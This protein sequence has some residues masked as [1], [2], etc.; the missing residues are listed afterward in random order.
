MRPSPCH[1]QAVSR[2]GAAVL[3]YGEAITYLIRRALH[4]SSI[5]VVKTGAKVLRQL[6]RG[7][8]Q[9]Y[10]AELRSHPPTLWNDPVFQGSHFHFW[11]Q[12]YQKVPPPASKFG[13]PPSA[14]SLPLDPTWHKPS[15][16]ELAFAS[17][18]YAHFYFHAL[19]A[20]GRFVAANRPAAAEAAGGPKPTGG[21]AKAAPEVPPATCAPSAP[22]A[23]SPPSGATPSPTDVTALPPRPRA[24]LLGALVLIKNL[25]R[26]AGALVPPLGT[27]APGDVSRCPGP[28]DP[29]LSRTSKPA[30]RPNPALHHPKRLPFT[31]HT[32]ALHH[33]KPCLSHPKRLPFTSHTPALHIPNPECLSLSPNPASLSSLSV[34]I[35]SRPAPCPSVWSRNSSHHTRRHPTAPA[36]ATAA[37]TPS[38]GEPRL[39][40]VMTHL[41]ATQLEALARTEGPGQTFESGVGA[42][43]E[44]AEGLEEME[45]AGEGEGEEDDEEEEDEEDED[46]E[47]SEDERQQPQQPQPAVTTAEKTEG[48]PRATGGAAGTKAPTPLSLN[49]QHSSLVTNTQSVSHAPAFLP[50][51]PDVQPSMRVR[52]PGLRD[53]HALTRRGARALH[54]L[55]AVLLARFPD[56]V[57]AQKLLVQAVGLFFDLTLSLSTHSSHSIS[58]M[59]ALP[60][61]GLPVLR[62]GAHRRAIQ[63]QVKDFHS[64]RGFIRDPVGKAHQCRPLLIMRQFIMSQVWMRKA[65]PAV[66]AQTASHRLLLDDLLGLSTSAYVKIRR[67]SQIALTRCLSVDGSRARDGVLPG[68]A[69]PAGAARGSSGAADA[70]LQAQHAP[71][72]DR[73]DPLPALCGPPAG[74]HQPRVQQSGQQLLNSLI[75]NSHLMPLQ[76]LS[77]HLVAAEQTQAGLVNPRPPRGTAPHCRGKTRRYWDRRNEA[78]R[79]Q[80]NDLAGYVFKNI[81]P[82]SHRGL[83]EATPP[84]TP[85]GISRPGSAEPETVPSSAAP[86]ATIPGLPAAVAQAILGGTPPPTPAA[87]PTPQGGEGGEALLPYHW[88]YQPP[89]S[90]PMRPLARF[91]STLAPPIPHAFHLRST[92]SSPWGVSR[93]VTIPSLCALAPPLARPPHA[94]L[95]FQN[96]AMLLVRPRPLPTLDMMT[97]LLQ[98]CASELPYSRS[99]SFRTFGELVAVVREKAPKWTLPTHG[100]RPLT[101]G[102]MARMVEANRMPLVPPPTSSP[103]QLNT[104]W[105]AQSFVDRNVLGW[106]GFPMPHFF[107]HPGPH[108]EMAPP[109]G[110]PGVDDERAT[111]EAVQR[112]RE[113]LYG[114]EARM[115]VTAPS[116]PASALGTTMGSL[117]AS[118]TLTQAQPS[119]QAAHAAALASHLRMAP[120]RARLYEILAAQPDLLSRI[121]RFEAEVQRSSWN[122]TDSLFFKSLFQLGGLPIYELCKPHV[123]ALVARAEDLNA[124]FTVAEFISGLCRATKGWPYTDIVRLWA[125]EDTLVPGTPDLWNPE[126]P[127]PAPVHGLGF[128]AL[129]D[130]LFRRSAS[131]TLVIYAAAVN[132]GVFDL[133][134]RRL[135][136]MADLLLNPLLG[137]PT[138]VSSPVTAS[139]SP[140]ASPVGSPTALPALEPPATTP[141]APALSVAFAGHPKAAAGVGV[142]AGPGTEHRRMTLLMPLVR[143]CSW[144]GLFYGRLLAGRLLWFVVVVAGGDCG[145][146]FKPSG[147]WAVAVMR[148]VW[149]AVETIMVK[150]RKV[151]EK[152]CSMQGSNLRPLPY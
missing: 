152:M 49:S 19:R 63:S 34:W 66:R 103:H 133:D 60:G 145:G 48:A 120:Y 106:N 105:A 67:A 122:L 30:L 36:T 142:T 59:P 84:P 57:A 71:P 119:H 101:S 8:T 125:N 56:D 97:I 74:P 16:P 64:L 151:N 92:S 148:M 23:S 22:S 108:C 95:T 121:F 21:D 124:Q 77:R 20:V 43:N 73:P 117:P 111:S 28:T 47:L 9:V 128:R 52:S 11:G 61:R 46:A 6:L 88:R 76:R 138:P 144:R 80:Y 141:T 41:P 35:R 98:N 54:E 68:A 139:T 118:N 107:L 113:H 65:R 45:D 109:A 83:D 127:A 131:N 5:K 99:S 1:L 136:W 44:S 13:A 7:L 86:A 89:P 14:E 146:S 100:W 55:A 72:D 132:M 62:P 75:V 25:A 96:M 70:A 10:P 93:Y 129:L 149:R 39:M 126:A 51:P 94:Q 32:P 85:T 2:A 102:D 78:L 150:E 115:A 12:R 4:H 69:D 114:E 112:A 17:R 143:E 50:G 33:P 123:V 18:L 42:F 29:P 27:T 58:V 147:A 38:A 3:P 40:A 90:L 31:S 24:A 81:A 104:Q 116:L 26:G 134:P 82:K 110:S 53:L 37:T 140:A 135:Q 79:V 87:T 137:T 130:G 15:P 91:L